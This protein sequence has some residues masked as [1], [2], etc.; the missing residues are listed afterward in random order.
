MSFADKPCK[1]DTHGIDNGFEPIGG[2]LEFTNLR[3]KNQKEVYEG[4]IVRWELRA[5][6]TRDSIVLW[7]E[8][9]SG[10]ILGEDKDSKDGYTLVSTREV[11]IIGDIYQNPEL[12]K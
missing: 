9:L 2:D 8:Y 7:S 1:C 10:F 6:E 4:D 12:L 11:S 5:G 3:D